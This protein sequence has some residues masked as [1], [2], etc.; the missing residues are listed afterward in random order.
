[1]TQ[2]AYIFL[3]IT[4]LL[5]FLYIL[6]KAFKKEISEVDAI[7]WLTSSFLGLVFVSVPG[8]IDFLLIVTGVKYAPTAFLGILILF[9]IIQNIKLTTKL[10][11]IQKKQIKLTQEIALID[12]NV[13]KINRKE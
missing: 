8:S 3:V 1:M 6:R 13:N 10:Y 11:A 5:I 4:A 12:F 9:L 2:R 7:I